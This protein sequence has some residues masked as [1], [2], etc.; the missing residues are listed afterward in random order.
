M[1]DA[2]MLPCLPQVCHR[3]VCVWFNA[4]FI[5][6]FTIGFPPWCSIIIIMFLTSDMNTDDISMWFH[7]ENL[8]HPLVQVWKV[9]KWSSKL[10]QF[11]IEII[12]KQSRQSQ[13]RD[14]IV[15]LFLLP[16]N[17]SH[18]M[19]GY[20]YWICHSSQQ[21]MKRLQSQREANGQYHSFVEVYIALPTLSI[22]I[23]REFKVFTCSYLL[24]YWHLCKFL[25]FFGLIDSRSRNNTKEQHLEK[26]CIHQEITYLSS[27]NL[28][29][30]LWS[31]AKARSPW[32][33]HP[34]PLR[35]NRLA[36]S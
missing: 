33:F 4:A 2:F 22:W 31:T 3:I 19:Q 30:A 35:H 13:R 26:C 17:S 24:F 34:I 21:I 14:S 8:P 15:V 11:G 5:T 36:G 10:E 1:D 25:P 28:S 18:M 29:L 12:S 6:R 23:P 7:D 20:P 32:I 9:A 16:R 27:T